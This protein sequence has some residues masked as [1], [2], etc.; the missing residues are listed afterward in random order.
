M[1]FMS[2]SLGPVFSGT[3]PGENEETRRALLGSVHTKPQLAA[4]PQP[5]LHKERTLPVG[6]YQAFLSLSE[7]CSESFTWQ[8][9]RDRKLSVL[10]ISEKMSRV[11]GAGQCRPTSSSGTLVGPPH[12]AEDN[13]V[14]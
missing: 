8:R 7:N 13:P 10:Y 12:R 2:K 5:C 3:R 4:R 1:F 14:Q 6:S 11:M 9:T